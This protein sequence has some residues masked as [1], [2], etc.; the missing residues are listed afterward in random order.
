MKSNY[1]S[2]E[3]IGKMNHIVEKDIQSTRGEYP[4]FLEVTL[5]LPRTATFLKLNS[6]DQKK[7]YFR[8]FSIMLASLLNTY[9][10][11]E[12]HFEYCKDGQIHLHAIVYIKEEAVFI[13]VGLL[14]DFIK[15]YLKT[16]PVKQQVIKAGAFRYY[17]ES[18]TIKYTDAPICTSIRLDQDERRIAW[19]AYIRKFENK[20]LI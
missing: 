17:D 1:N 11:Q 14:S 4:P 2:E 5:N 3:K 16:L 19:L 9:K 8:R 20:N 6:F 18:K 7:L 10:S 15:S 13:A 12:H